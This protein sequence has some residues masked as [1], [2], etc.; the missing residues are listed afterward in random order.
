MEVHEHISSIGFTGIGRFAKGG[1]RGGEEADLSQGTERKKNRRQEEDLL[2]EGG[3]ERERRG[4]RRWWPEMVAA[5]E[6]AG[7]RKS[8]DAESWAAG[9]K[10]T[11]SLWLGS[12]WRLFFK[13]RDGHTGQ[14]TVPVRCTP[15]SAQ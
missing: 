15:D 11:E 12:G 6:V 5:G 13:T 14:S 3:K 10:E 9:R 4:R 1:R 8:P 7:W 2:T